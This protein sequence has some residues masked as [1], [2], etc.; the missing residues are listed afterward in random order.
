MKNLIRFMS[1]NVDRSFHTNDNRIKLWKGLWKIIIFNRGKICSQ[2]RLPLL[3]IIWWTV[4]SPEIFPKCWNLMFIYSLMKW[5]K[6]SECKKNCFHFSI[7]FLIR[8]FIEI[9][10][11]LKF[12][13]NVR[14]IQFP[15][16]NINLAWNMFKTDSSYK[17]SG[18]YKIRKNSHVCRIHRE[19]FSW[20]F[21]Q[22]HAAEQEK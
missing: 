5:A 22:S 12:H 11:F 1:P 13:K 15:R 3:I 17:G 16:S 8:H 6:T 7:L 9:Y 4:S 18:G 2:S 19:I 21:F 10:G 20:N 14:A